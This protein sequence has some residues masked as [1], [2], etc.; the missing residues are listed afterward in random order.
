MKK[1]VFVKNEIAENL[2]GLYEDAGFI[3][4]VMKETY[5]KLSEDINKQMN[6][7]IELGLGRKG[8]LFEDREELIEFVKVYCVC[9]MIEDSN[10]KTLKVEGVPFM[11]IH[12]FD[13]LSTT[14][15]YNPETGSVKVMGDS[16][17]YL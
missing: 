11:E 17:R 2:K 16:Y 15:D 5:N 3:Q 13:P 4:D 9:E 12:P 6:Y 10:V 14:Y 1:V 7:A 8:Y